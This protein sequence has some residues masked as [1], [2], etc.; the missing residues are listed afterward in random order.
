VKVVE[1]SVPTEAFVAF[2]NF[3]WGTK[4]PKDQKLVDHALTTYPD[5]DALLGVECKVDKFEE[6][7]PSTFH[8][9]QSLSNLSNRNVALAYRRNRFAGMKVHGLRVGVSN[10]GVKMLP[11]PL[12]IFDFKLSK[13][14]KAKKV[15]TI[16]AHRPPKRFKFLDRF[17]DAQVKFRIR[18]RSWSRKGYWVVIMDFNERGPEVAKKL[19]GTFRGHEIDGM[20]LGPKMHVTDL[21]VD[22]RPKREGWTDHVGILGKLRLK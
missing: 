21:V 12:R 5:L 7:F 1:N 16:F 15:R 18:C 2:W 13:F 19:G 10:R 14:G 9:V 17:F 6:M 3:N 4:Q 11:R 8:I 20:I 22:S